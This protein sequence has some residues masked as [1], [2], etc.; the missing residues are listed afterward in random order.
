MTGDG[1]TLTVQSEVHKRTALPRLVQLW[2][3]KVQSRCASTYD[4]SNLASQTLAI[5]VSLVHVEGDVLALLLPGDLGHDLQSPVLGH[6]L[7][8]SQLLNSNKPVLLSFHSHRLTA[9]TF[10]IP[11]R[12]QSRA[13][14]WARSRSEEAR[15]WRGR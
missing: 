12:P 1:E 8:L 10:E 3:V 15:R 9:C 6:K 13:L 14:S 7:L 11:S 5:F 4:C 2:V